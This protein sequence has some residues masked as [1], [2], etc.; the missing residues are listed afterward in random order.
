LIGGFEMRWSE[1]TLFTLVVIGL[2][3]VAPARPQ[4]EKT[5]LQPTDLE[6]RLSLSRQVFTSDEPITVKVELSNRSKQSFFVGRN[7]PSA[8]N[9]P[10]TL[11]TGLEDEHGNDLGGIA[12]A[13]DYFGLYPKESFAAT[14]S[15]GWILL[16]PG[17]FYGSV[18][19]VFVPQDKRPLKPGRYRIRAKYSSMGL[20]KQSEMNLVAR[21]PE[22]VA[23]LP[24]PSWAGHIDVEPLWIKI[25]KPP[26]KK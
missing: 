1:P 23:R 20:T 7:F 12:G 21:S 13:A 3:C 14:L 11:D 19:E 9:S 8:G 18:V 5:P 17:F 15:N 2:T 6:V 22:E 16:P 25:V 26:K 24:F 4:S 10:S